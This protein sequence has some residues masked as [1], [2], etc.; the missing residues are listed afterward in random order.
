MVS[1]LP[2][3]KARASNS[4][5]S[6]PNHQGLP[7]CLDLIRF[8]HPDLIVPPVN[9]RFNPTTKIG[10]LKWVV[11]SPI[12]KMGSQHG[13]DNHSHFSPT[14]KVR[15]S[16]AR[17]GHGQLRRQGRVH[18]AAQLAVGESS[19]GCGTGAFQG[20][21]P[22][23]FNHR[24]VRKPDPFPWV[25]RRFSRKQDPW[26]ECLAVLTRG[27]VVMEVS[28]ARATKTHT[29][30]QGCS[31]VQLGKTSPFWPLFRFECLLGGVKPCHTHAHTTTI[32]L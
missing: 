26:K 6:N 32:I 19:P 31:P 21:M 24:S 28:G 8:H 1:H 5:N 17:G 29:E 30:G 10:S 20:C 9:I 11:S 14:K 27:A 22:F 25:S 4:P 12:P 2:S 3:T 13:F 23:P 16:P 18:A 15:P 7:E